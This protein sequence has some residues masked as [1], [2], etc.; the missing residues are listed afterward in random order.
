[1]LAAA[2]LVTLEVEQAGSTQHESLVSKQSLGCERP[3]GTT[4]AANRL[5]VMHR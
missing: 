4:Q 3:Q 5:E 1:M 2:R